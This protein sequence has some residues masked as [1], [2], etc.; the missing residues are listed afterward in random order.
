MQHVL[1]EYKISAKHRKLNPWMTAAI[2]KSVRNKDRLYKLKKKHPLSPTYHDEFII[3]RNIL[4]DTIQEAKESYYRK[5]M[6]DA[7]K[8]CRKQWRVLNEITGANKQKSKYPEEIQVRDETISLA[9][10]P[11]KYTNEFNSFFAN[12][13]KRLAKEIRRKPCTNQFLP[14]PSDSSFFLSPISELEIA[15]LINSLDNDKSPGFDGITSTVIKNTKHIITPILTYIFNLSFSSGVFPVVLKHSVIVPI[16]K[17]G[18]NRDPN[19]YRPIALL[20]VFS[21][22]LEKAMKKRLA[23]YLEKFNLLHC[24]QFGFREKRSTEHAIHNLLTQIYKAWH[25]GDSAI[26]IFL[27]LTKAFGTVNHAR[28]VKK[29]DLYGIR[30]I[31]NN[32]FKDYLSNRTQVT[33]I[34]SNFSDSEIVTTGV[35]QGSVV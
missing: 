26:G 18:S 21:K 32:W 14:R 35:P 20:S 16:F 3:Y 31:T 17:K 28:L 4:K 9:T 1:F 10:D 27:D 19:N 11:K 24:N 23:Q 29:L 8:D 7:K 22:L 5:K 25:S 15:N 6:S 34:Y 30:G 2:L 13:G 33:K 12:V